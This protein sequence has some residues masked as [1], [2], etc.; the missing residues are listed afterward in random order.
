MRSDA[1]CATQRAT[2]TFESHLPGCAEQEFEPEDAALPK[3]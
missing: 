3:C 1:R 2:L